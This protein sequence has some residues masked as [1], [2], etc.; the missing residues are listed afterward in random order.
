M[1]VTKI[2]TNDYH[3]ISSSKQTDYDKMTLTN[4]TV[5]ITLISLYQHN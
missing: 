1:N 3:N 5:K 2:T 4:C